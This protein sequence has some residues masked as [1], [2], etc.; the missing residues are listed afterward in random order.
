MKIWNTPLNT[1]LRSSRLVRRVILDE[2]LPAGWPVK[3]GGMYDI[4]INGK[5]IPTGLRTLDWTG[6]Q[7]ID[8]INKHKEDG[9]KSN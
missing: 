9:R 8:F 6:Q 2:N 5:L 7:W 1:P 3:W 4:P